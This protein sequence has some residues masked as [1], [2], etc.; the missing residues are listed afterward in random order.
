MSP[1]ESSNKVVFRDLLCLN[2]DSVAL[3][4]EAEKDECELEAPLGEET[5]AWLSEWRASPCSQQCENLRF[6]PVSGAAAERSF[7]RLWL[8]STCEFMLLRERQKG[9]LNILTFRSKLQHFSSNE[10]R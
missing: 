8:I 2:L 9:N 1:A 4:F 10:A 5:S 6:E 3:L 7:S